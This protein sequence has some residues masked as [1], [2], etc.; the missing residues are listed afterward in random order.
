M[1]HSQVYIFADDTKIVLPISD[2][3]NFQSDINSILNWSKSNE[4]S[5]NTKI[6]AHLSLGIYKSSISMNHS[7]QIESMIIPRNSIHRDL[8][9]GISTDLS[10][11]S[12]YSTIIAKAY[13]SLHLIR[14]T[15]GRSP[16]VYARKQLHISLIRSQITYCSPLWRPHLIKDIQSLENV[17]RRTTKFILNDYHLDYKLRLTSL[18][19][20]PLMM[21]YELLD[22]SLF[23]CSLKQPDKD[24]LNILTHV[25]FSN[26]STGSSTFSKLKHVS[27]SNSKH[28]HFYFNRI[29]L[30]ALWNALPPINI[31]QSLT[32]ST[33]TSK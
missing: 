23:I 8:G 27:T 31:D 7:Y 4:I 2:I 25:E 12:H 3:E 26:Y 14:R 16:S 28:N 29:A 1:K 20:L 11:N 18:K 6:F 5:F 21:F 17:Q 19:L 15:F 32:P 30:I 22:I 9:V 33:N 13:K 10:W 24:C